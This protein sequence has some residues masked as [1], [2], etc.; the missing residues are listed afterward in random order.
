MKR[1][2]LVDVAGILRSFHYAATT[3]ARAAG[4]NRWESAWMGAWHRAVS[5]AFRSAYLERMSASNLLPVNGADRNRALDFFLIEKCLYELRYEL[6]NRPEWIAVPMA[7]LKQLAEEGLPE[8][9]A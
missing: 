2:P 4:G 7:G 5:G 8:A 6:D 9:Q 3:A 1:S